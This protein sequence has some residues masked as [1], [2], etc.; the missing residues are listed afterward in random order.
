MNSSDNPMIECA[1]G[2]GTLI[3]QFDKKGRQRR[4]VHNHHLKQGV[5]PL[6]F[7]KDA[8]IY[9]VCGCGTLIPKFDKSGVPRKFANGHHFRNKQHSEESIMKMRKSLK[10]KRTGDKH[11]L[12]GKHHNEETKRKI[13]DANRGRKVSEESREKMSKAGKGK[14][15]PKFTEEHCRNISKSKS[16]EKSVFWKGGI[17]FEPYCQKFNNKLKEKIR[18]RDNRT[19]QNC[20][21][22]EN[23]RK[24]DVHHIHYDKENCYPDLITVCNS[25]NTKAN[26]NR[27]EWE[28]FYMNK[29]NERGLLLWT[30]SNGD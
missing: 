22:K 3:P 5:E 20:G 25:C 30:Q 1:C 10:G 12:Y 21:V 24:H 28:I 18:N 13:G 4:F 2:C 29:L 23:G 14:K 26:I 15:K 16:G 6:I 27:K 11:P 8:V 19:C 17:S 9:C 7:D